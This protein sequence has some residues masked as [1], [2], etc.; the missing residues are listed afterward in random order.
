MTAL[1]ATVEQTAAGCPLPLSPAFTAM[2]HSGVAA[3]P[4]AATAVERLCGG[5]AM[6][7]VTWGTPRTGTAV[8]SL[9]RPLRPDSGTTAQ[10]RPR[11][12]S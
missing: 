9:R 8:R 12:M 3:R 10:A 1:A 6:T 7:V 4:S 11:A 2:G 5:Q